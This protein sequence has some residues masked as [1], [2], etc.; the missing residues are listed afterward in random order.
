[1][2]LLKPVTRAKRGGLGYC[3]QVSFEEMD[4]GGGGAS[5]MAAAPNDYVHCFEEIRMPPRLTQV[6]PP[7]AGPYRNTVS[8]IR[9]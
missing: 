8:I 6:L 2:L 4:F 1:M 7:P 3:A 5:V 9:L